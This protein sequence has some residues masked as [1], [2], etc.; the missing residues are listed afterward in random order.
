M[1]EI[2]TKPLHGTEQQQ[3]ELLRTLNLKIKLT[4]N[5]SELKA[6]DSMLKSWTIST[7]FTG[8]EEK[9]AVFVALHI[10]EHKIRP[11]VLRDKAENKIKLNVMEANIIDSILRDIGMLNLSTFESALVS[12]LIQNILQQTA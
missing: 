8:L 9:A 1:R 2:D 11:H 10:I 12:K 7:P 6:L 4:L 3:Y 5:K